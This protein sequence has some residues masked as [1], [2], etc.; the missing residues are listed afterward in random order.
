MKILWI[1]NKLTGQLHV[2]ETGKK[3]TGGLWLEAMIDSARK[4]SDIEIVIVNVMKVS[5]VKKLDDRNIRYYTIPGKPNEH[6]NYRS[7]KSFKHW[8]DIINEEKPDLIELWGTE[9]PIGLA[10]LHEANN[11]PTIVYVQGVLESIGRYYLAGMTNQEIKKACTIRDIL[12]RSTLH[13]TQKK[14]LQRSLIESKI[15]NLSKNIIVENDW[16]EA[17]YKKICPGVNA[18]RCPLSISKEFEEEQWNINNIAHYTIMCS[19]ANYPIKGLHMLL[20]ALEIVKKKYPNVKLSVPGTVLRKVNDFK[21]FIKQDGYSKYIN[22]LI[23]KL[24]LESNIEYTGRL[25]AKEMAKKMTEVNCFIMCSA[26]EN[27]SSTLKEAMT[28]GVPCIASY[29]GG[30]PEYGIHNHNCLLYR[31]E[32]Y[33]SLAYYIIK[34]FESK[35]LC[36]KLSRNAINS[37]IESRTQNDFY[38]ISKEIYNKVIDNHK[39]SQR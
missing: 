1:V 4:D 20:K 6:Y 33:E 12:T 30:V 14:Y 19:A 15:I 22:R 35:D 28:V 29:V 5:S 8:R 3:S 2:K 38:K 13:Q 18:Y 11:I 17:Y 27:H 16:A 25:T 34:L 7:Y 36:I 24:K 21:S 26:I 31:F 37:M 9:M 23:K 32:D 39:N 10:A